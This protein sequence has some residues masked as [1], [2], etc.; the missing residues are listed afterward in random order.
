[1]AAPLPELA[2]AWREQE[3]VSLLP[4]SPPPVPLA[5]QQDGSAR[6]RLAPRAAVL[7]GVVEERQRLPSSE[8]LSPQPLW[9]LCPQPLSARR[10]P[11]L[12]QRHGNA[13]APFPRRQLQSSWSAFFSQLRQLQANSQ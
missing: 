7:L 5:V 1:L 10:L 4:A 8:Q 12:P 2:L 6:Q 9:R 11:Q 13:G 3:L